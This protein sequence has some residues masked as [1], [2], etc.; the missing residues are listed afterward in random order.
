MASN[1]PEQTEDIFCP[2]CFEQF[3]NP[4]DLPCRHTICLPCLK[5]YIV[6]QNKGK[7]SK[8]CHSFPCPVC[9]QPV[10]VSDAHLPKEKIAETFPDNQS[11][12]STGSEECGQFCGPCN[13]ENKKVLAISW[14]TVCMDAMCESC[15]ASHKRFKPCKNHHTV[16]IENMVKEQATEIDFDEH[17]MQHEGKTLEVYCLDHRQMCCVIC[18]ATQHRK[19]EH[20]STFEEMVTDPMDSDS[21][22]N[23]TKCLNKMDEK[24]YELKVKVE[25][26]IRG[27]EN[28]RSE[29]T[30]KVLTVV[31]KAKDKLDQL[32]TSFLSKFDQTHKMQNAKLTERKERIET[33]SNQV[34]DG[35]K[36]LKTLHQKGSSKQLF[37]FKENLK[38]KLRGELESL[39]KELYGTTCINYT[40]N[41]NDTLASIPKSMTSVAEVDAK[42]TSDLSDSITE[43]FDIMDILYNDVGHLGPTE[44]PTRVESCT[45]PKP[46]MSLVC[47]LGNEEH[48]SGGT[49]L[50][51]GR[52]VLCNSSLNKLQTFDK[53]GKAL[54]ESTVPGTL[55][56]VCCIGS[57]QIVV[58]V[59]GGTLLYKYKVTQKGF[60]RHG[61]ID[62]FEEPYGLAATNGSLIVGHMNSIAQFSF[63]GQL[64]QMLSTRKGLSGPYVSV[65]MAGKIYFGDGDNV[66]CCNETGKTITR[67]KDP[68]LKSPLGIAVDGKENVLVC[69]WNSR[70]IFVFSADGKNKTSI[71]QPFIENPVSIG[72]DFQREHIFIATGYGVHICKLL[73]N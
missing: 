34:K 39:R 58:C 4:K 9:R 50:S 14:C 12:I 62:C 66:V 11:V 54:L 45:S 36:M 35:K 5:L 48:F 67:Y 63:D 10:K 44:K 33:F 69:G 8:P 38:T 2:I 57:S 43:M 60:R 32:K 68:Q 30:K 22:E 70:K 55:R 7:V 1:V 18:L 25:E 51:D 29:I 28:K 59:Q 71:E 24:T 64:L 56:D 52:L 73:Y 16:P 31:Q 47:S 6:T 49:F 46:T 37:I 53:T 27:L 23:F 3:T 19:C 61:E 72:F 26:N 41:I 21:E 65:S 17:C 20:V 40:M 15:T 42:R 13:E